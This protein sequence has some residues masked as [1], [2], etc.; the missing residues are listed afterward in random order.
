VVANRGGEEPVAD[1]H[2]QRQKHEHGAQSDHPEEC[3]W[4]FGAAA[5]TL[6]R[7]PREKPA[8]IV[9]RTPVPGVATTMSEVTRNSMLTAT[10]LARQRQ[11]RSCGTGI[12]RGLDGV[13]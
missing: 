10:A 8:A 6:A 4:L 2:D 9:Y 11:L 13:I 3:I 1:E 5:M 7:A 12:R